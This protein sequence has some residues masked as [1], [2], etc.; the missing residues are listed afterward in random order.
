MTHHLHTFISRVALNTFFWTS[1]RKSHCLGVSFLFSWGTFLF[2]FSLSSPWAFLYY[3]TPRCETG[4]LAS[5]IPFFIFTYLHSR[6]QIFSKE[7]SLLTSSAGCC[8]YV[9]AVFLYC[10][11]QDNTRCRQPSSVP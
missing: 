10:H 9:Y 2:W 4:G 6:G 1:S 5:M 8:G 11:F 7:S 3:T